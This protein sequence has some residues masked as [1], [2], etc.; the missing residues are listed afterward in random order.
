MHNQYV[1][2]P[3]VFG[4]WNKYMTNSVLDCH[5]HCYFTG[6]Y[7]SDPAGCCG[8]A[9]PYLQ[10]DKVSGEISHWISRPFYYT[11]VGISCDNG[12]QRFSWSFNI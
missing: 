11:N 10:I 4:G 1:T 2:D 7:T 12:F 3:V 8:L 6:G 9:N 5:T